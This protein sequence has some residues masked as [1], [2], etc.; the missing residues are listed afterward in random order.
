ML[1]PQ[2]R[3]DPASTEVIPLPFRLKQRN[4]K[5]CSFFEIK[6][7]DYLSQGYDI[8]SMESWLQEVVD[9]FRY[10]KARE[11]KLGKTRGISDVRMRKYHEACSIFVN[12]VVDNVLY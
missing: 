2:H 8:V 6:Y 11:L 7:M 9:T 5:D 10:R 3:R 1:H 4:Y 12:F